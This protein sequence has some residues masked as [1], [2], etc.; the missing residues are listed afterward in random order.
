MD[1]LF[2]WGH[3]RKRLGDKAV[4]SQ[5]Y[6]A[7]FYWDDMLFPTAEHWMMY[8]KACLFDDQKIAQQILND[9]YPGHAKEAGRQV[10]NFDPS[11]WDE[12][13]LDIVRHG[14]LLKFTQ[15]SELEDIL[16]DTGDAW[17]VEASPY[18]DIW[19][20]GMKETHKDASQPC[21]WRGQNLLGSVLMGVRDVLQEKTYIPP[22]TPLTPPDD[23]DI[24]Y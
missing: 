18:D 5:F 7:P 2:F 3:N 22:I 9:P 14:N 23:D 8:S 10:S 15:N 4:F 19:G 12:N 11:V 6:G 16:M 21:M 13:K 20:I 1:F 24:P 17:L